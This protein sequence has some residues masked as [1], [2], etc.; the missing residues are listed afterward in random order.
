MSHN[1]KHYENIVSDPSRVTSWTR[2]NGAR[3]AYVASRIETAS[4]GSR[5]PFLSFAD[6]QDY[7]KV[8]ECSSLKY[9][10]ADGGTLTEVYLRILVHISKLSVRGSCS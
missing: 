10:T 6:K 4:D 9:S 1:Y 8:G 5:I 3:H 7:L 2:V